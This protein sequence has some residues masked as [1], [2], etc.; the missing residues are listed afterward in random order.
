M[1]AD[2]PATAR[3]KKMFV[4][5]AEVIDGDGGGRSGGEK[6]S[7][8]GRDMGTGEGGGEADGDADGDKGGGTNGGGNGGP[9]VVGVLTNESALAS[10]PM[11]LA[12]SEGSSA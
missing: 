10:T 4:P 6:V 3:I 12:M 11:A 2:G 5:D 1:S 9:T 8:G 7:A